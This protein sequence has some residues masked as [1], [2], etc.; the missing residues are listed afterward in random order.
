[1]TDITI[2]LKDFITIG[3]LLITAIGLW[4]KIRKVQL[5][6]LDEIKKDL[7]DYKEQRARQ[8][9]KIAERLSGLET[10]VRE[11]RRDIDRVNKN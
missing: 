8:D 9:I 4:L 1:M 7:A 11:L 2:N 3:F 6:D 10:S 5:N